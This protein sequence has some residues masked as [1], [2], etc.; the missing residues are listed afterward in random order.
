MT[1][2]IETTLAVDIGG[3]K[4]AVARIADGRILEQRRVPTP[5]TGHGDD[6]VEA[7]AALA[8]EIAPAPTRLA[9]ATTGIV[10][11]GRLTALNPGT[12][13]VENHYPLADALERRLGLRPLVVN[14][15]QAAAYHESRQPGAVPFTRLAFLTVSTGIGG[16][17]VFDG[18]LQTGTGGL[19][20]HVGHMVVDPEGP[21]CGCGRRG[22]VETLASGTAIARRASAAFRAELTAPAVFAAADR[23]D[24]RAEHVVDEAAHALAAMIADLTAACD[25]DVV[26][27]GGGVGLAPGFAARVG[28]A[29]HDVPAVFRRPI[30]TA[31]GGAD[32]GLLG[33]A[34][35]AEENFRQN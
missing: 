33:A 11:G 19:A 29:L 32:A 16:G 15:A 23:G 12:L 22:C 28:D 9:V 25:P 5:R 26:R 17:L 8:A 13:P 21:A 14:D 30:E 1:A 2:T 6:L 3:T 7:V 18:R 35:L 10:T 34:A 27:L 4:I 31:L 20:G 24:E